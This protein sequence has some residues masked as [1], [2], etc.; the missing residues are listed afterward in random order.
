[1]DDENFTFYALHREWR[2]TMIGQTWRSEMREFKD[3][4]TGRAIKQ[5]T[6]TGNNVHLYFTENSFD[7]HRNAIIFRS[8]RASGEDQAPHENPVYN[9]FRMDLDSGEITQLSDE[10][11][12]VRSV[13]KTPDS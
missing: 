6:S 7:A 13:T 1:M 3:P 11:S 4:T 2:R 12:A 10:T 9:L 8:D 5:L